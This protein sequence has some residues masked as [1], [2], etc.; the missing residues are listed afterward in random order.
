MQEA[1]KF[2]SAC[3]AQNNLSAR[4]CQ[5]CGAGY[6]APPDSNSAQIPHPAVRAIGGVIAF[7]LFCFLI[8]KFVMTSAPV[9]RVELT[10]SQTPAAPKEGSDYEKIVNNDLGRMTIKGRGGDL[11][12]IKLDAISQEQREKLQAMLIYLEVSSLTAQRACSL[13]LTFGG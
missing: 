4:F 2:C 8:A 12:S 13:T 5:K 11:V 6:D 3:G 1:F 10:P 9:E 7:I